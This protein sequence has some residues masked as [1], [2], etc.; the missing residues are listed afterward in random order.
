MTTLSHPTPPPADAIDYTALRQAMVSSQLRPNAVNDPRVVVAMS[1][2]ARERF[3]PV[4]ARPFAYLDRAVPLG[5]ARFQNVPMAT[6]RLLTEAYLEPSDRVLLIGAT[7]GYTAAVLAEIVARVVAVERD[8]GLATM[9]RA[10]LAGDDRVVVVEAGF[11]VGAPEHGP[12]DVLIIDGA[13]DAVPH[14]LVLQL[15]PGGRVTTGLID[16]SLVDGGVM[17]LASGRRSAGGFGLAAFADVDCVALP[18][19]DRPRGFV[20]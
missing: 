8:P 11:D 13:V 16:G 18:G 19:F 1:R 6:G 2:V 5:A 3:L 15:V 4:A 17:R 14:A 12:Y 20:F 9:A 10:A 7:G